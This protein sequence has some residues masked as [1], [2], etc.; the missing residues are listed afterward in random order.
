[1]PLR[2]L[3]SSAFGGWLRQEA[4]REYLDPVTGET[5]RHCR[6]QLA[7][8]ASAPF[9][10]GGG[11]VGVEVEERG[12]EGVEEGAFDMASQSE[13]SPS[14]SPS[15][16]PSQTTTNTNTTPAGTTA[17]T[18]AGTTSVPDTADS[19]SGRWSWPGPV[20]VSPSTGLSAE[21]ELVASCG[22]GPYPCASS[23]QRKRAQVTPLCCQ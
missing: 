2:L 1:M 21:A 19:G 7:P 10:S 4:Y 17:P 5:A 8:V 14:P 22:L 12:Q 3:A 18:P 15:P 9:T 13:V 23:L 20:S 6:L 11:E 16:S